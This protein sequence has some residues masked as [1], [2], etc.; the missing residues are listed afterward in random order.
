MHK[1]VRTISAIMPLVLKFLG[2]FDLLAA[3][4]LFLAA[5]HIIPGR[6]IL[7]VAA[8]LIIKGL[9][10]HG[11]PVSALDI[12]IGLYL[13]LSTLWSAAMLNILFGVYLGLKGIYSFV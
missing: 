11:G 12:V 13:A 9:V 6:L 10:F 8:A 7:I 5:T 4:M 2:L 3:T 1:Y